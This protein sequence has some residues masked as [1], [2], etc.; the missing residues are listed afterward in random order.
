MEVTRQAITN[1]VS[2]SES[3]IKKIFSNLK[4]NYTKTL[5]HCAYYMDIGMTNCFST[6]WA[7]LIYFPNPEVP[8]G[9][10]S[11]FSRW[12]V[13]QNLYTDAL[14]KLEKYLNIL[15]Y[16]GIE[17]AID[18]YRESCPQFF[19]DSDRKTG[20]YKEYCHPE[21]EVYCEVSNRSEQT[22]PE[23]R[24]PQQTNAL[25]EDACKDTGDKGTKKHR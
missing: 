10:T 17:K 8:E 24:Y 20:V 5:E 22:L 25:Q 12:Y 21:K 16:I 9:M 6:S 11:E 13:Q 18:K 1:M 19:T 14:I 7:M 23:A 3:R 4:A 2:N 15:N